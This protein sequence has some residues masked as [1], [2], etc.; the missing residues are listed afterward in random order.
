MQLVHQ[1]LLAD[2]VECSD[3][4]EGQVTCQSAEPEDEKRQCCM[5]MYNT[6]VC[7]TLDPVSN[8]SNQTEDFGFHGIG[9]FDC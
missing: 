5:I 2:N 8:D 6:G 7:V 1:L 3:V 4:P 9:D